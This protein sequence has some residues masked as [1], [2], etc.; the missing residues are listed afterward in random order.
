MF[1]IDEFN[2][3]TQQKDDKNITNKN[4]LLRDEADFYQ[5]RAGFS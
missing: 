2:K 4:I 3:K 1:I 5:I